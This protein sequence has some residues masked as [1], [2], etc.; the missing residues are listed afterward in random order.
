MGRAISRNSQR[1]PSPILS[2]GFRKCTRL[3]V[4]RHSAAKEMV[5]GRVRCR[6][7]WAAVCHGQSSK[8]QARHMWRKEDQEHVDKAQSKC[9]CFFFDLGTPQPHLNLKHHKAIASSVYK[10]PSTTNK[11]KKKL[12]HH[13]NLTRPDS[14]HAS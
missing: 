7:P 6:L 11:A 13:P 2:R 14:E 4:V 5:Y 3:T 8:R 10:S 1:F 12:P 9:R